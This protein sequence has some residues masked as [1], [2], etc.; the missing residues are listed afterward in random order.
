MSLK[1]AKT[2]SWNHGRH[3]TS[4]S[5]LHVYINPTYNFSSIIT[6]K[7][8]RWPSRDFPEKSFRISYRTYPIVIRIA[9]ISSI[10]A[11]HV[12]CFGMLR[13]QPF[14]GTSTCSMTMIKILRWTKRQSGDNF[15]LCNLL[16]SKWFLHINL[17]PIRVWT[18]T[19]IQSQAHRS[20]H[21]WLIR[22]PVVLDCLRIKEPR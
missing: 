15:V 11:G 7:P 14:I 4:V 8:A 1:Y 10:V 3:S 12:S 22:N 19:G 6:I 16:L 13:R 20:G 5:N 9:K 17:L 21:S 2:S 18:S